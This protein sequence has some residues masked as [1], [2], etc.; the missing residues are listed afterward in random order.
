MFTITNPFHP[1]G[2]ELQA[3]QQVTSG[4]VE[5]STFI[6]GNSWEF[7]LAVDVDSSGSA[8]IT[9]RTPSVD[10]P[11]SDPTYSGFSGG[12]DV[13]VVKLTPDGRSIDYATYIGGSR[14][15]SGNGISVDD[16]VAYIA[17]E[18]WS[19]DFPER[20]QADP[21]FD[22]DAFVV[23]L[24][25]DGTDLDYV[26]MLGGQDRDYAYGIAVEN[27][28]AYVTGNTWSND[29]GTGYVNNGDA[30]VAKLD[31]NGSLEYLTILGGSLFDTG[32][33]IAVDSE[34]ATV[35]GQTNSPDFPGSGYQ[36][37][38]DAFISRINIDGGVAFTRYF[39][40]SSEDSGAAVVM[41]G[42]GNS[43]LTGR[44]N[45][46][47]ITGLQGSYHGNR[48]AFFAQ[49]DDAGNLVTGY[50]I[51]G[52][53]LDEGNA[54]ARNTAGLVYLAGGTSSSDF[55]VSLQTIQNNLNGAQDVFLVQIN[56]ADP[57]S[58]IFGTYLGG[59]GDERAN[60]VSLDPADMVYL[61]G[62]T[63]SSNFPTTTGALSENL[64]GSQDAFAVKVGISALSA[65]ATP[66]SSPTQISNATVTPSATFTLSATQAPAT[67]TPVTL[68]S[69][70]TTPLV[71]LEQTETASFMETGGDK[72]SSDSVLSK[73]Q[74]TGTPL[75]E[76]TATRL[77]TRTAT[78]TAAPES[79]A[80]FSSTRLLGFG[81]A[82]ILLLCLIGAIPLFLG[83][84]LF[85]I[86][87]KS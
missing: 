5:Y 44:S 33:G 1:G 59:S 30:Y 25:P 87:R 7:G 11:L 74:R 3:N 37:N 31:S 79:P 49:Y 75:A 46:A 73:A 45:S 23:A 71:P 43:Y 17:G 78:L 55:P 52:S 80:G 22:N 61:T 60:G 65:T 72:G 53:G 36:G 18:T 58:I 19:T 81:G 38:G 12:I 34:I 85:F 64:R 41:D 29:F 20:D 62:S 13:F 77:P 70:T 50:Y 42:S 39:G 68:P 35:T 76:F 83:I 40:G 63:S 28:E 9:G 2:A 27:N 57:A 47:D 24:N 8:Y 6:G 15:E 4:T 56:P 26:S 84:S 14:D 32:F 51:G 48:D 10:F 21:L 16:G 82:Y 67:A 69:I 66:V 54:I 86:L